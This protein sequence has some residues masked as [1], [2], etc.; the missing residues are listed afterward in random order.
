MRVPVGIILLILSCTDVL[1]GVRESFGYR[2]AWYATDVIV[3][4]EGEQTKGSLT[5]L[6]VWYGDTEPGQEIQT[7]EPPLCGLQE[8]LYFP[9]SDGVDLLSR[10]SISVPDIRLDRE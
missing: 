3:A 2:S 6:E 5:A 1:G 9:D 10:L 7:S 8:E 4:T